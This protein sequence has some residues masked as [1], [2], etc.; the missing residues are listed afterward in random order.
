MCVRECVNICICMCSGVVAR[1][2]NASIEAQYQRRVKAMNDLSEVEAK[3]AAL[4]KILGEGSETRKRRTHELLVK[5]QDLE[6]KRHDYKTRRIHVNEEIDSLKSARK[7]AVLEAL[8]LSVSAEQGKHVL[9]AIQE[10]LQQQRRDLREVQEELSKERSKRVTVQRSMHE[11]QNKQQHLQVM[12]TAALSSRDQ[13]QARLG[14]HFFLIY[15]SC[16]RPPSVTDS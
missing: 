7:Q 12:Y 13:V 3:S 9:V 1:Q 4:V 15:I 6:I 11:L 10:T 16:T 5:V 14:F 2:L 8:Q